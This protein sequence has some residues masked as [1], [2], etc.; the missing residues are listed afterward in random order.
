M[1][2]YES[3]TDLLSHRFT[4]S[5]METFTHRSIDWLWLFHWF[6]RW[7]TPLVHWFTDWWRTHSMVH[8]RIPRLIHSFIPCFYVFHFMS[9][10]VI[11]FIRSFIHSFIHSLCFNYF[12]SL[13][14]IP[15][16]HFIQFG[17]NSSNA[18]K[19]VSLNV[20]LKKNRIAEKW[21]R[22]PWKRL[23]SQNNRMSERM[24]NNMANYMS[25]RRSWHLS[26]KDF[27]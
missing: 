7:F 23:N 6:S 5:L 19:Y 24:P 15:F 16:A 8:W 14:F 10:H 11:S 21:H 9:S 3:F 17:I 2:Q 13:H 20:R 12:N 22:K 4:H 27:R 18:S 25:Y 26:D 1:L